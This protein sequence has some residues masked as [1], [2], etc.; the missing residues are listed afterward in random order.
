[1][2]KTICPNCGF[3]HLVETPNQ[4]TADNT[5]DYTGLKVEINTITFSLCKS[6]F[7]NWYASEFKTNYMPTGDVPYKSLVAILKHLKSK[8]AENNYAIAEHDLPNLLTM[9]LMS[10]VQDKW[11][12]ENFSLRTIESQFNKIYTKHSLKNRSSDAIKQAAYNRFG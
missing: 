6:A 7:L 3:E 8:C 12:K 4:T 5:E 10:A 9:F 1:M 2:N 11:I